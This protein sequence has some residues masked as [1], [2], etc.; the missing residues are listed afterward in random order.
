MI[1][2]ITVRKAEMEVTARKLA[3]LACTEALTFLLGQRIGKDK[4]FTMV[5]RLSQD[6]IDGGQTV[7]SSAL[8]SHDLGLVLDRAIIEDIFEPMSYLGSAGELVDR[9]LAHSR[10]VRGI[11]PEADS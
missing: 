2:C 3:D 7:R 6:A 8:A 1:S 9:V 10:K 11:S 5:H 4:A